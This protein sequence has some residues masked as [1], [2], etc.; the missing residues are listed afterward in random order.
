MVRMKKIFL[1]LFISLLSFTVIGSNQEK[2][3]MTKTSLNTNTDTNININKK[4]ISVNPRS[5]WYPRDQKSLNAMM[6]KFFNDSKIKNTNEDISTKVLAIISPHAGYVYSGAIAAQAFSSLLTATAASTSTSP[7]YNRVI[8]IGPSHYY[9]LQNQI[10]FPDGNI[11]QT[12]LGNIPLDLEFIEKLL[13]ISN[14]T[15][16]KTDEPFIQEHSVDNEI[17][18]IQYVFNTKFK[19][20]PKIVPL[21][22]GQFTKEKI[23]DVADKMIKL[24]DNNTLIVIS[25]DFTHY[26]E[27]FNYLPF[28]SDNNVESNLKKLD[29]K[30]A[31]PIEQ[32]D[33]DSFMNVIEE[34]G[35]TVCG[36]NPIALLLA[37]FSKHNNQ[38]NHSNQKSHLVKY[39]TSGKMTNDF[40]NSV[41]YLSFIFSGEW[42]MQLETESKHP[43]PPT[44]NEMSISSEEKHTLLKIARMMIENYLKNNKTL[45]ISQLENE[46]KLSITNG[47][48][49]KCGGFV[50]LKKRGDLRGCIGEIMPRR[51]AIEVVM[52]RAI[53]AAINDNRFNPVTYNELKE[54]DIEISLLTPPKKV[55]SY[56]DII[57]G[58]HG[59][60]LSKGS[61]GAVFL[62][63]VAP[64][65]GWDLATTLTYLS[66]KAGLA[67]D[68]WK[69]GASFEVFEAI[70]FAEKE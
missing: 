21:I 59:M 51:S 29:M 32:L 3:S 53:D 9:G 19:S 46:H 65:Q 27:N 64:E 48:K 22:M 13:S 67:S 1:Y 58:K 62:P 20:T 35:A 8:V 56:N 16:I 52:E 69:K 12:P 40:K 18:F 26:G 30:V 14:T 41:S 66:Q 23:R 54:I 6:E 37:L 31:K 61:N 17:P 49:Q 2:K 60:V 15:F 10:A 25:S 11:Y 57:I 70:V 63:Q 28:K 43:T 44:T 34:T 50:T 24:I 36:H 7:T 42:K 4:I 39:E 68:A 45:T 5:G 47:L 38:N 55:N 33:F